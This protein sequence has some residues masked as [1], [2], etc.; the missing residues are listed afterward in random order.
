[1]TT[2]TPLKYTVEWGNWE[3]PNPAKPRK[4]SSPGCREDGILVRVTHI[5]NE[6]NDTKTRRHVFCQEHYPKTM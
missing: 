1:M 5:R 6:S 3:E 4:C 2:A